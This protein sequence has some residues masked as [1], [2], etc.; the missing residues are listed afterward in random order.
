MLGLSSAFLRSGDGVGE[1]VTNGRECRLSSRVEQQPQTSH[2]TYGLSLGTCSNGFDLFSWLRVSPLGRGK[3]LQKPQLPFWQRAAPGSG[4]VGTG[5]EGWR[6][7]WQERSVPAAGRLQSGR[8][9]LLRPPLGPPGSLCS[10]TAVRTFRDAELQLLR[11]RRS[12]KESLRP[13]P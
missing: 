6:G 13:A 2:L 3:G 1:R 12:K 11:S 10:L 5:L 7:Q 9:A 8:S 4:R